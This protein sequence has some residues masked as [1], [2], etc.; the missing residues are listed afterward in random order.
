MSFARA[1]IVTTDEVVAAQEAD[2]E[3]ARVIAFMARE[4][5]RRQLEAMGIDPQEAAQRTASLSDGEIQQIAGKLDELPAGQG[6]IVLIVA[7]AL[8]LALALVITDI[9]GYTDIYPFIKS[10]TD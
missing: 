8:A 1:A 2:E 10:Q 9:L 7:A 4:D 6:V 5:V 3:R